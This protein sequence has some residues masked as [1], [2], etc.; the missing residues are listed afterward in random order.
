MA[1]APEKAEILEKMRRVI[2]S[3]VQ[4]N[5]AAAQEE[6][7]TENVNVAAGPTAHEVRTLIVDAIKEREGVKL[8]QSASDHPMVQK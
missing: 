4:E 6:K 5:E 2:N 7:G 3:Q 1:T 8:L